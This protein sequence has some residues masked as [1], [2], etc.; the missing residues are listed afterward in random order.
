MIHRPLFILG[1]HRSGTT[2][3]YRKLAKHPDTGY[4]NRWNRRLPR[5][6][7]LAHLLT[8][9]TG[10]DLPME[11]Q[12]VWDRAHRGEDDRR[13]AGDLSDGEAARLRGLVESV[14]SLRN[15]T[16]FL[17][18]YPRLSL[19]LSWLDALFPDAIFLHLRRDWRAVVSSTVERRKK[20]ERRGG[21]WFGVRVPGWRRLH[22]RHHAIVAGRVFREVTAV[23]E[24]E[25]PAYGDRYFT[26]D[27]ERLCAEPRETFL[28]IADRCDLR[29]T[30]DW[31]RVVSRPLRSA[32]GKW[33]EK[34]APG[35]IDHIRAGDPDFFARH[36]EPELPL[37]STA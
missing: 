9:L 22:G 21:G 32:N 12:N 15:A 31:E 6:P 27:Y 10:R 11:A 23:L 7:G 8:R 3:L 25:G 26:V 33:R 24:E 30:A 13:T 5:L 35:M 20:R 14:L 2:L 34:V 28:E 17:A 29:W 37:A 19:R 4:L 1:P 18:K 36:E 16:R